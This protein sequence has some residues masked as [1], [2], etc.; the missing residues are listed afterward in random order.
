MDRRTEGAWIIH[1]AKK[2]Q[3]VQNIS[4]FEDIEIAGKCGVFLSSLAASNQ[5]SVLDNQKV[6]AIA[7]A[8]NI[9]KIELD[10]IKNTLSNAQLIDVSSDGSISVIG[11]TTSNV[12]SHTSEIFNESTEDT[13]QKA[14]IDLTDRIADKPQNENILKENISDTYE[15]DRNKTNRLFGQAEDIGLIDFESFDNNKVYFNGNL[16]KRDS[17][18]KTTRILDSLKPDEMRR[19]NEL[20]NYLTK[21]GCVELEFAKRLLGE[22]LVKR[23]QS[24]AMYDF[25]EVSNDVHSKIFLTKPSSF[26]K[27]G[28]P[29]VD[30]ALDLAK[31]FIA[32][33]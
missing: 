29:F 32:S 20:D 12:L 30:D 28:N 13:Y 26:S 3:E 4:D 15:L 27:F 7:T 16:F 8:S 31:A 14:S 18:Q 10:T 1:H 2:V 17:I 6:K 33:L 23:L 25:S 22:N 19:V 11:I 9:K 21:E 5:N 24:I